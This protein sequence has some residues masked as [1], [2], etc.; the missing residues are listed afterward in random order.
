VTKVC[1]WHQFSFHFTGKW[2]VGIRMSV[3]SCRDTVQAE[4]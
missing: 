2:R 4:L 1:H 3:S